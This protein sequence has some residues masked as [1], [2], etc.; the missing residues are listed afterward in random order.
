MMG[1]TGMRE[2]RQ[3]EAMRGNVK[4]FVHQDMREKVAMRAAEVGMKLDA[5]LMTGKLS[6]SLSWTRRSSSHELFASCARCLRVDV[7]FSV[8]SFCPMHSYMPACVRCCL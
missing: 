5:A 6:S 4:A 2:A 3:R 7:S 1:V 8:V